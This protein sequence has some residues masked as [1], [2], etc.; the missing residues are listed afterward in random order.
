MIEIFVDEISERATYTFDFVLKDNGI[1]YKFNN[2]FKTFENSTNIKFNY[3][4]RF[5]DN[6]VQ[7]RPSTLL[8]EESIRTYH[9]TKST[10]ED[11]ECLSLDGITDPFAAIFFVLSRMEEYGDILFDEH[12][13]FPA[14]QSILYQFGWLQKMVCERW[15]KTLIGFLNKYHLTD[16]KYEKRPSELI[17]TFDID[18][19]YAYQLKEGSRKILSVLKD[20]VKGNKARLAERKAV[21]SR[22]KKDPYDTYDRIQSIADQGFDVQLFW[23]LGDFGPFDKNIHFN[24]KGQKEL[25][26]TLAKTCSIGIHPSYK[27][28]TKP[29]QLEIEIDR[30]AKTIHQPITKSRQHYLKFRLPA[31]Y[32]SL[33]A[34]N[35]QHD[36]TMGYASE[37]GYRAGTCRPFKWFDLEKN[38]ATELTIHP[39]AYM[40]GTL[41]EYKNFDVEEAKLI[42]SS[43]FEEFSQ[44]GGEFIFLWHNETIGDY[45]K[46]KGWSEVLEHTL[47][48]R[49]SRL[50]D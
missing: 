8:F 44:F 16:K 17:P 20:N 12:E 45:G 21:L 13:R 38:C 42:I 9:L 24:N 47:Q 31:T 15:S 25:I 39:F 48:L 35:I 40:D 11:E 30:L 7:L 6:V 43:L 14:K 23:L 49:I 5:F 36:Y 2:D 28:N 22:E 32:K 46:W 10:F 1:S 19:A 33:I 4:E 41:L 27:S 3:S 34:A 29:G 37:V 26:Q 18:N 50:T